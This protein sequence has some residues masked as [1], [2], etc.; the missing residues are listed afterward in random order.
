MQAI[1]GLHL[2]TMPL[3]P[4]RFT[5]VAASLCLAAVSYCLAHGLVANDEI[6][7][8]RTLGW[9]L[10]STLPWAGAWE[11]MKRLSARP[12]QPLRSLLS[13]AL[14]AAALFTNAA[15]AHA[16]S[17][18]YSVDTDSFAQIVYRLLPIP[19]GIAVARLLLQPSARISADAGSQ[20]QRLRESQ[21]G[22]QL[23]IQTRCGVLAVRL[24]DIEYIKA[25]GN[26]VEVMTDGRTLLMRMTLH[27]L[28]EQLHAVGFVRVHRSLIVNVLHV[29]AARRGPRGR[30][31]VKLNGGAQLPVGRQFNGNVRSLFPPP[32]P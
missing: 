13:L 5:A 6:C 17:A 3:T 25:A 1:R 19:L 7:L 12:A 22:R 15:L 26:Y 10:A 27:D 29:V 14:L 4:L 32:P 20:T 24:C 16:L 28:G 30:Q 31:V 18:I 9:A 23:S 21:A 8:P 2:V 11:A